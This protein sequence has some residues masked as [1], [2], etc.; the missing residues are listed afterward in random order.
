MFNQFQKA[1]KLAK[2]TGDKLIIFDSQ[3]PDDIFVVM[4]LSQYE[5]VVLNNSDVRGLTEQ[6]MIDKINRDI[7]IWKN[8]QDIA[9]ENAG[10]SR[11]FFNY[12]PDLKEE[13]GIDNI[14]NE[15]NYSPA[16]IGYFHSEQKD[17]TKKKGRS[18]WQIPEDRK[19]AAEEIIEEDR[20]YLE[21][22]TF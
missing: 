6:E 22:L 4:D 13:G 12:E 17:E 18:F 21:E 19:E 16:D 9:Q 10:K 5:K 7:A 2:K 8:D 1:I 11:D 3:K 15:P 20:Q 14:H